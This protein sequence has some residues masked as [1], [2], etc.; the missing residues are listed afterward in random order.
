M[1]NSIL[2]GKWNWWYHIAILVVLFQQVNAFIV[3]SHT[4]FTLISSF[5]ETRVHV[6]TERR[7]MRPVKENDVVSPKA[8]NMK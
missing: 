6:K 4:I 7:N 8:E 3:K 1:K 5:P 2:E